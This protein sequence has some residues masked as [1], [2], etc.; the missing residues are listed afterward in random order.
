MYRFGHRIIRDMKSER[1]RHSS[2][3]A[4][5]LEHPVGES[6]DTTQCD[7]A[8]P[9]TQPVPDCQS[10]KQLMK[11]GRP[12][13]VLIAEDDAVTALAYSL[14]IEDLGGELVGI[15][16]N[17]RDTVRIARAALPDVVLMDVGLKGDIDGIDTAHSIRAQFAIPVV[18]VTGHGDF[19]TYTRVR[20]LG[21]AMPVIKPVSPRDL[22]N[23]IARVCR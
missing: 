20:D 23:A 6:L 19:E 22:V 11:G 2:N 14:T 3:P 15:A 12:L 21:S 8:E 10:E 17:A 7:Q 16:D 13:R 1:V 9:S 5:T 4:I 18:F